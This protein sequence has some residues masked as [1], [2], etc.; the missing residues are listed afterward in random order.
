MQSA[1]HDSI[2]NM[3]AESIH[4]GAE[5]MIMQIPREGNAD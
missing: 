3:E 4:A 2:K 1:E 5:D